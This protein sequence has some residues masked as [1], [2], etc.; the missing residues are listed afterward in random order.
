MSQAG[1]FFQTGALVSLTGDS[2]GVIG[3][4]A[5][6]INILGGAGITVAG[7]PNTLTIS[8]AGVFADS[9]PT[10][11]G[12]AVPVAG[13]TNIL[14]GT[15]IN[16]TGAGN[17]VTVI[18]DDSV[19]LVGSLTAGTFVT[20]TTGNIT[21]TAGNINSG[22]LITAFTTI[23]AGTGITSVVGD[24]TANAGNVV[25]LI[26]YGD[27]GTTVT[28]GTGVIATTGNVTATAGD[29]VA[30]ADLTVGVD[31]TLTSITD[32]GLIV[33]SSGVV[34]ASASLTISTGFDQW[35][36]GGPF[37]DDTVLGSFEVLTGGSGYINGVQVSWAGS[38]TVT[39]LLAG[40]TYLIYID[41]T[42][43]IGKTTTFSGQ[44][45]Y[46]NNIPL[47][48]VLRDS[49][50]TNIQYTVKENHPFDFPVAVSVYNHDAIG[51][52]IEN[53]LQGAN[54]TLNGTQKIEIV[55]ADELDDHGLHTVIPDGGGVAEVWNQM[56]TTGAGKW[57]TYQASDTF[58]G[59]WNS[60]GT[61]TAGSGTRFSIYTLYVSKDNITVD[62]PIYWAV[63]DDQEYNNLGTAETAIADGTVSLATAELA[64]LELAQLG[65]IIYRQSTSTIVEVIIEKATLRA[66][67]STGGGTNLASLVLTDV[68]NF[69]GILSA[70][71]TTVQVALETIDDWGLPQVNIYYVGKHGN[72]ANDGL[73]INRAFLTFGAAIA[74]ASSGDVV[75]CADDGIYTENITG[76][77]GIN[78]YAPNAILAG[79]HSITTDNIWTFGEMTV[80]TGVTGITMNTASQKASINLKR[81]VL[82]GTAT[83]FI[84]LAGSLTLFVERISLDNGFVIGSTTTDDIQISFLC[85]YVI[86]TG[87]VFGCTTGGALQASGDS[88]RNMGAGDGTAFLTS[89]GGTPEIHLTVSNL[90]LDKLSDITAASI[91]SLNVSNLAGTLTEIGAGNVVI[92]GATKIEGVP[93][94]AVTPSTGAFTTLSATTPVGV[95]SG[96]TGAA[97]LTD[98]GVLVGSGVGAITPL[99]VGTNGQLLV[100]STGADP[101]FA[102]VASAD[103]SIEVT[104]GAGTIDLSSTG[105]IAVN[106][107]TG[108]TYE[109]LASDRGK[110]VTCTNAAAIA[111]TIP[112]NADVAMDIGTN[113]LISQNGAG[114]VTLTPEGGVTLRSRGALL[115]TAGQ[116]AIASVTKI[117]TDEWLCGGDLA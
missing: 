107:Q 41:D 67:F 40:N 82:S 100:G 99:A 77:S 85:L 112:V 42:G 46:Q 17:T 23:E 87:T 48:E 9:F 5:G 36:G 43:T 19:S 8:H 6:N 108:T 117:A 22:G 64:K 16:T 33:D 31:V 104:G 47:F 29:L 26:G 91:V 105:T 21:T 38:Q 37:F 27:F 79:S 25:S 3:P 18:L 73:S 66:F 71:D 65:H 92:G 81:I 80:A 12:T 95:A 96:G 84:C 49:T 34:S 76:V 58:N 110:I 114:V 15:N 69:D 30:G 94:G 74:A 55:G 63:L 56:Y 20:A 90:D 7:T 93:I 28:G 72:D 24:I 35:S 116:Y 102:T 106:N 61:P 44:D 97:T 39:G 60:A 62:T 103:N 113:V 50:G 11:A 68:A 45:A 2:G 111:V 13:D 78:I 53:Q 10:D 98:H 89:G 51:T 59:F 83:G 86:G 75:S 70:S 4:V 32:G 54:I 115:D 109:L 88:I 101:V 1:Q 14:G 52:I 57:A